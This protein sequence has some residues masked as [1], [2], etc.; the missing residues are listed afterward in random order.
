VINKVISPPK[1]SK[2]KRIEKPI[3]IEEK[4]SKIKTPKINP[5]IAL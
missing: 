4:K 2:V 5:K 3:E 1:E